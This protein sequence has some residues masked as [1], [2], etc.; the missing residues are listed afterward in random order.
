MQ[1]ALGLAGIRR[2]HQFRPRQIGHDEFRRR[3]QPA[4]IGATRE[5]MA[6]G[7]PEFSHV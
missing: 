2:R 4:V 1:I 7:D 5:V 3:H 6:R